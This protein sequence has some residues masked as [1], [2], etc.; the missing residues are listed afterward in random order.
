MN[1]CFHC[2]KDTPSKYHYFCVEHWAKVQ[3]PIRSLVL[4]SKNDI[5]L[6]KNLKI[7]RDHI[8]GIETIIEPEK[9]SR[10]LHCKETIASNK[11]FCYKHWTNLDGPIRGA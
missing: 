10:C 9:I 6:Q 8:D 4:A 7:A 11:L 5:E 1:K 3:G 2:Q